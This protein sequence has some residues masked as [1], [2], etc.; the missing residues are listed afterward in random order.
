MGASLAVKLTQHEGRGNKCRRASRTNRRFSVSPAVAGRR[1]GHAA[2]CSALASVAKYGAHLA[3][4]QLGFNWTSKFT[5]FFAM[6][7]LTR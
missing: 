7:R 1:D 3:L 5:L 2:A 6:P 4:G